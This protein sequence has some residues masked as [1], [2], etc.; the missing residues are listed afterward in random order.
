MTS[1]Q[2]SKMDLLIS[3][4]AIQDTYEFKNIYFYDINCNID[5]KYDSIYFDYNSVVNN[6]LCTGCMSM[7]KRYV[8]IDI[9]IKTKELK[10][11]GYTL[12]LEDSLYKT[13]N[14]L[15]IL[16]FTVNK[17]LLKSNKLS[18]EGILIPEQLDSTT[19]PD[20]VEKLREIIRELDNTLDAI[21]KIKPANQEKNQDYW[22][23]G[24]TA[25]PYEQEI[26]C[27]KYP[28]ILNGVSNKI[29]L[30]TPLYRVNIKQP[31][32]EY[33]N[34]IIIIPCVY[35]KDKILRI[36]KTALELIQ[37]LNTIK[38]DQETTL[39]F[40]PSTREIHIHLTKPMFIGLNGNYLTEPLTTLRLGTIPEIY[41]HNTKISLNFKQKK[42]YLGTYILHL[43]DEPYEQRT[44]LYK[45]L[46]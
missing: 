33:Q 9:D 44:L 43:T 12:P 17:I 45:L 10:K 37:H 3:V 8:K 46:N 29:I 18:I 40:D 2:T 20:I 34:K 11:L 39:Q 36:S 24:P 4:L 21:N 19:I 1:E 16:E 30:K 23:A 32:T 13:V 14:N 31:T 35:R 6:V 42:P 27:E 28:A 5:Y 25:Y 41:P 15:S 26:Y 22:I 38:L 7:L